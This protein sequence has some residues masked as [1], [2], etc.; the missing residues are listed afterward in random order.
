MKVCVL[1]S[2]GM[3]SV[4]AF[5]DALSSHELAGCLSFDYGSKHNHRE[6]IRYPLC[7]DGRLKTICG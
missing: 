2:G 6:I 5:H 7:P 3:D 1:L 4:T